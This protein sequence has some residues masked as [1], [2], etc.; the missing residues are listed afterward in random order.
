MQN[1][2]LGLQKKAVIALLVFTF[3]RTL[4]HRHLKNILDPSKRSQPEAPTKSK[5]E[6][7]LQH[8]WIYS[9]KTKF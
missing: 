6:Q 4:V 5:N 1:K 8:K 7:N 9:L 2:V 3:H